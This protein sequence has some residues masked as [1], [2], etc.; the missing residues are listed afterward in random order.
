MPLVD[1]VG[2][3][4]Q[5]QGN[6]SANTGRLV[7]CYREI[8]MNGGKSSHVIRNVLGQTLLVDTGTATVRAMGRGNSKNWVVSNGKLFELAAAGTVT[9][10]ATIADDAVTAIDGNYSDV[11]ITAGGLYYVW[12][13]ATLTQPT[14]KTFTDVA[15]HFF[16]GDYTVLL[17]QGGKRFQWSAL[18]DA[19]TL[20]ALDFALANK[21]DDNLLRGFEVQGTAVL[22]CETSAEMWQITGQGGSEAFA[23]VTSWNRGLKSANLAVKFDDTLFFIGD[24]NNVYLGV[25]PGAVDITTPAINTALKANTATHC[26]YY[27]D[28]GHKFCVLRF[29]DRAAWVFD[30]KQREWHE[31]SEGADVGPFSRRCRY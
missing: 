8:V 15:H 16:I 22:F 26:F 28:R 25:G 13:G 10:R 5:D 23:F 24:D 27:E 9:E 14:T 4:V 7:N 1:F 3:S 18:G 17:E 31:R 6:V 11:T 2:Q 29:S 19:A 30:V 12:D 20:D 21:S